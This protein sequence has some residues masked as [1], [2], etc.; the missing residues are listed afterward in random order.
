MGQVS[1]NPTP[2]PDVANFV[3]LSKEGVLNLWLSYNLLGEGWSLNSEQFIAL[4][5]ESSY[6][7]QKYN[8]SDDQLRA[9]F[10]TFDTD[11]NGLI[12][13]L[14]FLITVALLSGKSF[15]FFSNNSFDMDSF[16]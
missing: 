14:E 15:P 16:G 3:N 12:D 13:A 7:R 8:F 1:S 5:M 6:L 11:Q 2:H 10:E 4:F 9:L